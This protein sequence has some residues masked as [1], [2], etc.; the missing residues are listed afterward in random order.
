MTEAPN[1][2]PPEQEG[3]EP[4]EG[5]IGLCLSGGGYRAMLYH[6]GV[7]WR[8]CETGW[9]PRVDQVSSVSGGSLTAAVLAT[10]WEGLLEAEDPVEYYA[11]RVVIRL[12]A[13]AA[14]SI[15][16]GSVLRG[17]LPFTTVGERVERQ[18]REH[19]L[20][21]T[22]LAE[23]PAVPEFVFHATNT[24]TGKLVRFS[25]RELADW[26]VGSVRNPDLPLSAAVTASAA[27]PPFLSP[28]RL[29]TDHLPWRNG[30]GNLP[31]AE[32]Y[33]RELVLTDG[34][35]YDNLGVEQVWRSCD[36]V[37]VSDGGGALTPDPTP[38][39]DP[40]RHAL[41]I[42]TVLDHQVRSLRIR[43]VI[44][45]FRSEER[46]GCYIGIRTPFGRYADLP[47][48]LPVDDAHAAELAAVPTRLSRL[49][50]RTQ[51]RLVNWGYAIADANLRTWVD[52]DATPA[53]AFPYPG[54][55]A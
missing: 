48:V 43:Q 46:R 29:K 31:D 17:L 12:R 42:T 44:G 41:R 9:L 52:Q 7:L 16:V 21:E 25:R 38:G 32:D 5:R 34:G 2:E 35:V 10:E 33:R 3:D 49:D 27:C 50:S 47:D 53:P 22:T 37:F 39:S 18:L 51:E 6:A 45:G 11:D 54:G 19:L 55:T 14:H 40:A 4:T 13:L 8:L 23:L 1:E 20:G 28:F 24:A 30:S 26:R 15:D 36:T